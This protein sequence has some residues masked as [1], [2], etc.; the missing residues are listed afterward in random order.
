M[1]FFLGGGD[2]YEHYKAVIENTR[3]TWNDCEQIKEAFAE[4][5]YILLSEHNVLDITELHLCR[6]LTSGAFTDSMKEG[7][8]PDSHS[9]PIIRPAS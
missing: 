2:R 3:E 7:S 9:K 6:H 8:C 4:P 1:F 5:L